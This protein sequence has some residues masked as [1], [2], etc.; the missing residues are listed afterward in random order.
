MT[1]IRSPIGGQRYAEEDALKPLAKQ[2]NAIPDKTHE[3]R[4]YPLGVYHGLNF[5][6]AVHAIG[7]PG[8]LSGRGCDAA[9]ADR[10]RCR[11]ACGAQR[12]RP[13]GRHL[14]VAA[15]LY[16]PGPGDRR[17]P[18]TRP[19]GPPGQA[20]RPRRL[21]GGAGGFTRPAEGRA[22]AGNATRNHAGR[23]C[24]QTR[25][26]NWPE[27]IK[28]LKAAHTIDAAPERTAPRRMA[29]EEPVTARIRRRTV[30]E[31]AVEPTAD[32]ASSPAT[33]PVPEAAMPAPHDEPTPAAVIHRF[34]ELPSAPARPEPAY[35]QHFAR[36]R[37]QDARQL[38]LF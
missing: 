20:L 13:P 37:R 17:R 38:S 22:V 31:P 6:I 27:R 26:P 35:R 14:R 21:P 11:P 3:T 9:R 5:G 4:R 34:P 18:A 30:A 2:L 23:A 7:S 8:C 25:S 33:A 24:R 15:C 19:P 28:S 36:A 16:P 32:P 1:T 10:P 12:P 29:A